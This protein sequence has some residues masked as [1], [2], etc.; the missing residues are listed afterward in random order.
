MNDYIIK[1]IVENGIIH[2]A[3]FH[4]GQFVQSEDSKTDALH[5]IRESLTN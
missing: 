5:A 2:Y 4:N 3:I 1:P